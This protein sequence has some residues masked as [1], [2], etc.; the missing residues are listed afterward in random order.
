MSMTDRELLERLLEKLVSVENKMAT[1]DDLVN[2]KS[3]IVSEITA[4]IENSTED[5][6]VAIEVTKDLLNK[7]E[8]HIKLVK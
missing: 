5:L 8:H 4:K 6:R 2:V 3:E 1:K 7:H